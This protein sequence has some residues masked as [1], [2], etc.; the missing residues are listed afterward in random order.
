ML[1][2][3]LN[4]DEKIVHNKEGVGNTY[5]IDLEGTSVEEQKKKENLCL[6][7]GKLLNLVIK[8]LQS[9]GLY[10]ENDIFGPN[11]DIWYDNIETN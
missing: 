7:L 1:N 4:I 3:L 2:I 9:E 11:F 8:S 10:D 5:C 6:E